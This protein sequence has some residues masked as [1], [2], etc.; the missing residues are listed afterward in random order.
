MKLVVPPEIWIGARKFRI[1]WNEVYLSAK[2]CKGELVDKE[3]LIRLVPGRS[4]LSTFETLMHEIRH[5]INYLTSD[6][7][8]AG[9]DGKVSAETNFLCQ[10]LISVGIEPDFSLI[11]DEEAPK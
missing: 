1:R 5:E 6:D 8:D 2:G 9:L 7:A 11:P 10:A 3:D 4:A